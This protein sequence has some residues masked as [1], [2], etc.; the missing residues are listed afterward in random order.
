MPAKW[1]VLTDNV[2]RGWR[3][4]RHLR[5]EWTTFQTDLQQL[6]P[7]TSEALA[8]LQGFGERFVR[9]PSEYKAWQNHLQALET[10]QAWYIDY[11]ANRAGRPAKELLRAIVAAVAGCYPGHAKL[12]R[13]I[14][15]TWGPKL[16]DGE[17]NEIYTT[18]AEYY[19]T[20][21]HLARSLGKVKQTLK[22]KTPI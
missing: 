5:D 2:I 16:T 3:D 10:L 1:E 20:W 11:Y 8:T 14:I 18:Y 4:R 13:Y 9:E 21:N 15:D 12:A 19:E 17:R 7:A 6:G 22:R